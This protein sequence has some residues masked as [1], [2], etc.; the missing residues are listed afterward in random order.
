M[1]A[2]IGFKPGGC[3]ERGFRVAFHDSGVSQKVQVVAVIHGGVSAFGLV[4]AD[5]SF[6]GSR[7]LLIG[8]SCIGVVSYACVNMRGHVDQVPGGRRDAG[9]AVGTGQRQL[10]MRRSFDSMNVIVI[11]ARVIWKARQ[12]QLKHAN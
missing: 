3:I 8:Q 1:G 4:G 6:V 5:V 2:D 10:R 12:D 11:G 7:G 9:E